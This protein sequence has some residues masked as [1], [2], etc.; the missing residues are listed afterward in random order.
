[1]H[2]ARGGRGARGARAPGVRPPCRARGARRALPRLRPGSSVVVFHR[3]VL[4]RVVVLVPVVG[5]RELGDRMGRLDQAVQ[6]AAAAVPRVVVV[7]AVVAR[8]TRGSRAGPGRRRPRL[9]RGAYLDDG[10]RGLG[11]WARLPALRVRGANHPHH[12]GGVVAFDVASDVV[13]ARIVVV[14]AGATAAAGRA[15]PSPALADHQDHLDLQDHR[16]HVVAEVGL[17]TA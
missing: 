2:G 10:A 16:A 3:V 1:M 6:V 4:R 12:P 15:V 11:P 8:R 14:G 13:G 17:G 7:R 5:R 9:G